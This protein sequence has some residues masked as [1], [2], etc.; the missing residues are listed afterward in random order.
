MVE[1]DVTRSRSRDRKIERFVTRVVT[2][3]INVTKDVIT[4]ISRYD[5]RLDL[6]VF[7]VVHKCRHQLYLIQ[8][9]A[10]WVLK[11]AACLVLCGADFTVGVYGVMSL[12]INEI[13]IAVVSEYLNVS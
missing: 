1:S 4:S 8:S 10:V 13:Y 9:F 11:V 5:C 12:K 3:D 6:C 7:L 2:C